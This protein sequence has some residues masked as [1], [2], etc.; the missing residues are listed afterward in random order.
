M[1]EVAMQN[2]GRTAARRQGRRTWPF[3]IV[4]I[5][6]GL[7]S[8]E[9]GLGADKQA[10]RVDQAIRL[11][12]EGRFQ[13]AI[14]ALT[15]L[16]A[17]LEKKYGIQSERTLQ[18]LRALAAAH[19]AI[20]EFDA[21]VK[22]YGRCYNATEAKLKK[23]SLD[24]A[25]DLTELAWTYAS[26]GDEKSALRGLDRIAAQRTERLGKTH[27]AVG[28]VYRIR[29][30]FHLGRRNWPAAVED[31][32]QAVAIY[33]ESLGPK[34]VKIAAALA[35]QADGHANLEESHLAEPLLKE[36]LEMA[37]AL[38]PQ[39]DPGL[40]RVE[41]QL[42]SLY[43]NTGRPGPGSPLVFSSFRRIGKLTAADDPD[44]FEV[45]SEYNKFMNVC[46]HYDEGRDAGLAAL[47]MGKRLFG[48]DDPR[49]L[50]LL[51]HLGWSHI[52]L[53]QLDL[54][55]ECYGRAEKIALRTYGPA[56]QKL[57]VVQ[58]GL[59]TL[60]TLQNRDRE[61]EA[62]YRKALETYEKV[63]GG[64]PD[65]ANTTY[66]NL[67]NLLKHQQRWQESADCFTRAFRIRRETMYACLPVLPDETKFTFAIVVINLMR[68]PFSDAVAHQGQPAYVK[69]S[70]EWSAN[71]KGVVAEV[72]G[73]AQQ[74]TRA[75]QNPETAA[76]A[77][78]LADVRRKMA[79]LAVAAGGTR[80]EIEELRQQ[81]QQWTGK[82]GAEM[83]KQV[84]TSRWNTLEEIRE[85]L[86]RDTALVDYLRL[87]LHPPKGQN[88][89]FDCYVAWFIPP[90][91]QGEVK[92][93]LLAKGPDLDQRIASYRA[94]AED[95]AA[96]ADERGAVTRVDALAKPLSATLLQVFPELERYRRWY[97]SPD[98][99]LW[100]L[101]F[102]ALR[103]GRGEYVVQ[104]HD[105]TLLTCS[106]Q[107]LWKRTEKDQLAPPAIF[108]NP[109]YS[110]QTVGGGREVPVF[111]PL[112]GTAR[113]AATVAP[114][115]EKFAKRKPG[116][117]VEDQ[118]TE[119]KLATIT[120][121]SVLM[122]STHGYYEDLPQLKQKAQNPLL[123]CGLALAG[124]NR[125]MLAKNNAHEDG[126]L[127]GM[128]VAT[129]D[130][131]GTRLVVLSACQTGL[132]EAHGGEG[133]AGLR[134]AFQL[135][136]AQTIVSTLW[137][138]PDEETADLMRLFFE[139]LASDAAPD[140]AL[141]EAQRQMIA[142]RE[143]KFGAAHPAFWAAFCA[144]GTQ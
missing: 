18:V 10:D 54:T 135:A 15:P 87:L 93:A 44:A 82:L 72:L 14:A 91:G 117:Y 94:A 141:C 144:T 104:K 129:L 81:E 2:L 12:Q 63:P 65:S 98:S 46:S 102:A 3:L 119:Q 111:S 49:M 67:G 38:L 53:N 60:L 103:T 127:T 124:A 66:G 83:R 56:S 120:R 74:W 13:E 126:I 132:G 58:T 86:P 128:E 84:A 112:P 5:Y 116:V 52:Q 24:Y 77:R 142:D 79:L 118:A 73:A 115:L 134:Q 4:A 31:S 29:G 75:G 43:C 20:N 137:S 22:I 57:G 139:R 21:A 32:R 17:E 33:R 7:V 39:D 62:Q 136:G 19:R 71:Y 88:E 85:A 113:E 25:D 125:A 70:A 108:A 50:D 92:F 35:Q 123:R 51:L 109:N 42:A 90:A 8:S 140:T 130:L 61:A 101:P 34:H 96:V 41:M 107:L 78:Q 11:R 55:A 133:I 28:D 110:L 121:P 64:L 80:M 23:N 9:S 48:P 59:G 27:P 143:K 6:F 16:A 45:L 106:R 114:L 100:T 122:F 97:I 89:V 138:V 99:N 1:S 131:H 76:A 37:G 30:A 68:T 69:A 36:A 47:E 105:V 95:L 26:R 40:A